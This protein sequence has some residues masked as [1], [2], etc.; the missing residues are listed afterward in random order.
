MWESPSFYLFVLPLCLM[1]LWA[2]NDMFLEHHRAWRRCFRLAIG[3][4]AFADV[5]FVVLLAITMR[6]GQGCPLNGCS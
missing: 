3:A 5:V 6:R 4:T 1:G 2:L